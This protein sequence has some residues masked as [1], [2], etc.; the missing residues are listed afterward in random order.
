MI[1]G[2]R[3]KVKNLLPEEFKEII[4]K[5]DKEKLYFNYLCAFGCP[6]KFLYVFKCKKFYKI[7][8][9]FSPEKR[10][11]AIQTSN[12]ERIK[13]IYAFPHPEAEIFERAFHN[14]LKEMRKNVSGEWFLLTKSDIN[15]I[16]RFGEEKVNEATQQKIKKLCILLRK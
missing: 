4:Y 15:K 8:T 1:K 12:P 3:R 16:K 6:E 10:L 2:I 9:S 7:G 11:L 14:V 5:I 13:Q